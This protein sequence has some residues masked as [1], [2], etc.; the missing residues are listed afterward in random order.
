M[1]LWCPS[2]ATR[3][4]RHACLCARLVSTLPCRRVGVHVRESAT[5]LYLHVAVPE[6][7]LVCLP[8]VLEPGTLVY[9]LAF[10]PSTTTWWTGVSVQ[11]GDM[12]LIWWQGHHCS[13][14]H[15]GPVLQCGDAGNPI[16]TPRLVLMPVYSEMGLLSTHLRCSK[17]ITCLYEHTC[18][19]AES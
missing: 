9:M 1:H 5:P 11:A 15:H 13:H 8:C 2:A 7:T 16:P 4:C 18:L 12:F 19:S 10:F 3:L 14:T 6:S 17:T